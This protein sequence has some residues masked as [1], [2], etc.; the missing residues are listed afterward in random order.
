MVGRP[1]ARPRRARHGEGR[2]LAVVVSGDHQSRQGDSGLAGIVPAG[3]VGAR[4]RRRPV[5]RDHA[6]RRPHRQGHRAVG[7]ADD[8]AA[9]A[10]ILRLRQD[11]DQEPGA[12]T[13]PRLHRHQGR[14]PAAVG[15]VGCL[16]LGRGGAACLAWRG[17][18]AWTAIALQRQTL[19]P[20]AADM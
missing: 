17:R 12:R 6:L 3:D 16:L 7:D 20:C 5:R 1:Q 10:Q 18:G 13:L 19:R 15:G 2:V 8:R 4:R 11:R 14:H 9:R